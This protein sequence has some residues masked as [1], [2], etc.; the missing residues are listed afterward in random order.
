MIQMRSCLS[1]VKT[2]IRLGSILLAFLHFPLIG[3]G[4]LRCAVSTHSYHEDPEQFEQW[5]SKIRIQDLRRIQNE[6]LTI[7]VVFHII[8]R[9]E[10]VGQGRNLSA[11]RIEQ[12]LATLNADFRRT[13]SDASETPAA[14]LPVASDTQIEFVLA[15]RDPSGLPTSGITRTQ[16]SQ[17]IYRFSEDATLKSEIYW[18]AED[19]MNV[20]VADLSGFLGWA[21]FPF[22]NLA[23][24]DEIND[25]RLTDGVALDYSYVGINPDASE[26][27]SLGRTGTHEVGHFLGLKHV[28]GDGGCN[29]DDFC[30]DTP[31]SSTSYQNQCP[32]S[33]VSSCGSSDMYSNFLNYTDDACMNLFTTCQ[34]ERMRTVLANS[35]RRKSLLTSPALQAPVMAEVDL[36]VQNII[37][38]T[39][40][41]CTPTFTPM[42]EVRND[43]TNLITEFQVQLW[44]DEMLVETQTSNQALNS[45]ELLLVPFS[46]LSLSGDTIQSLEFR[47]LSVNGGQDDDA[48]NDSLNVRV[49]PSLEEEIPFLE[50]FESSPELITQTEVSSTSLWQIQTAPFRTSDNRAVQLQFYNNPDNIG[51]FHTL[52]LPNLDF[53]GMNSAD[54][55]FSYAYSGIESIDSKDGLKLVASTDCGTTFDRTLFSLSGN[56]LIT[57]SRSVSGAF[58]PSGPD[59]WRQI[60]INITSLLD[61]PDLRFAFIGQNGA[62]NHIYLDDI[63]VEPTELQAFDLGISG[64]EQLPVVTCMDFIAPRVDVTNFGFETITSY[65]LIYNLSNQAQSRNISASL[66]SGASETQAVAISALEEGSYTLTLRTDRPNGGSD[67]A[68]ANDSFTRNF[69]ID[70][71][72]ATL[73]IRENFESTSPWVT[74]S[75]DGTN[76]WSAYTQEGNTSFQAAAFNTDELGTQHWLVSPVLNTGNLTEG[77]LQF[78]LAY[79][80]NGIATDRLQ[81]ILSVNCGQSYDQVLYDQSGDEL[82]TTLQTGEFFPAS[83]DWRR[84]SIDLS[85]FVNFREI[86]LAFVFTN[87]GGNHLFIDNIETVPVSPDFVRQFSNPIVVYPQPVTDGQFTVSLNL[88]NKEEIIVSLVDLSGKVIG[89]FR[90][91]NGLNQTYQFEVPFLA[92]YYLLRVS[93]PGV[94]LSRPVLISR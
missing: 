63:R 47:V 23:G 51:E 70:E 31:T 61:F 20:Y 18:P 89:Q 41:L 15:R 19:Y 60:T 74:V 39:T 46:N 65:D 55:S 29:A 44:L 71:S 12:Q 17:E 21:S 48:S 79:A 77:T 32:G 37:S 86:R 25:N 93:G 45:G 72:E 64:V 82:N 58:V 49:I 27:P 9:G 67:G 3:V 8:H 34:R 78:D 10:P 50:S 73:P 43:G 42:A 88:T 87:G 28:W 62:A 54:L 57:T 80:R 2:H 52:I 6:V 33:E 92:G 94:D 24:I 81:I 5:L 11:E 38:P 68:P 35:I 40:G 56:N 16:G 59:E 14:F 4:Q 26:F 83:G 36:G 84:E 66:V 53:T 1:L 69:I 75:P 90:E 91:P 22:S 30:T 76:L 13:N 7:P 85:D